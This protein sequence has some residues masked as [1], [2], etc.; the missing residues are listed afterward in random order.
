MSPLYA[1]V[2]FSSEPADDSRAQVKMREALLVD[3][4]GGLRRLM[5]AE[6]V[7]LS[8]YAV[9]ELLEQHGA[10]FYFKKPSDKALFVLIYPQ[11]EN[12]NI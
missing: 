12:A 3:S 6:T 1:T 7:D 10:V 5:P 4:V 8:F 9:N 2:T 11:Y